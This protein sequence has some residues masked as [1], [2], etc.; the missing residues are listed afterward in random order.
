MHIDRDTLHKIAHLA[1]LEIK[2]EEEGS[3]LKSLESVLSWMEHLDE[4]DTEGVAPLTHISAEINVMR[5][6]VAGNHLTR[7]EGLFNAPSQNGAYF[8]VPKVIE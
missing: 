1:R 6:D 8:S 4:L 3:M 7:A 2:P 5:E